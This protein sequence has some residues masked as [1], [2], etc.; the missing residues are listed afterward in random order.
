MTHAKMYA[1]NLTRS[2]EMMKMTL[3]DFTDADML[4]RPTAGANH[5]AWQLGHLTA[6]EAR[7][8]AAA[9]GKAEPELPAGFA[10]KFKKDKA[11]SNDPA[12]F[13][14]KADLLDAFA[15]VRKASIGWATSLTSEQLEQPAPE[16][17]R[18]FCP[19]IGHMPGVLAEHAAMH[20]GQFQVIRRA[21]GK[22]V[23]FYPLPTVDRPRYGSM[24]RDLGRSLVRREDPPC[25]V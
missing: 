8:V 23:F 3:A 9:A 12:A 25:C 18:A 11:G 13:P 2:L 15:T 1:D 17:I 10:E 24:S 14:K 20:I 5:A 6:S 16:S 19:A 7:M 4:V 21:L 22:R